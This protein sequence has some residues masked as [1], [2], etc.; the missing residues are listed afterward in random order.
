MNS[1]QFVY[2]DKAVTEAR[3]QECLAQFIRSIQSFDSKYD[4]GRAQVS[5]R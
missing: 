5:Q 3:L 2:G 1:F 4:A